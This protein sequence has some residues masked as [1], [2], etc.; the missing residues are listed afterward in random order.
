MALDNARS[1]RNGL[2]DQIRPYLVDYRESMPT[3][4]APGHPLQNSLPRYSPLPGS[5]PDGAELTGSWNAAAALGFLDFTPSTSA[6]VVR[7]ELRYVAGPDYDADDENI[8]ASVNVGQ[9][10][11]FESLA[12]LGTP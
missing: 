11:H 12:G 4:L 6:S 8:V 7:H 1:T 10:S 5:T 9:P 2:Q 3:K